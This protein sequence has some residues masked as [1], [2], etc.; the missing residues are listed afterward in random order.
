MTEMACLSRD[1]SSQM[2]TGMY[3]SF[4]GIG[5]FILIKIIPASVES[6]LHLVGWSSRYSARSGDAGSNPG[7][8][9]FLFSCVIFFVDNQGMMS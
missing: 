3:T 1:A 6:T 5:S 8:R 7:R 4:T 2:H 9:L